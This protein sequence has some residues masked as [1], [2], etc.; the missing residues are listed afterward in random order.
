MGLVYPILIRHSAHHVFFSANR[1]LRTLSPGGGGRVAKMGLPVVPLPL[2][3]VP[4]A[5]PTVPV[6]DA[7]YPYHTASVDVSSSLEG[8]VRF[9]D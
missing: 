5:Y 4:V 1:V 9:E 7:G 2:I 6:Y 3:P 8:G